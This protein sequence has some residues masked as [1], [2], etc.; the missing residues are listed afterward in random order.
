MYV[1]MSDIKNEQIVSEIDTKDEIIND[2]SNDTIDLG[3]KKVIRKKNKIYAKERKQLLNNVFNIILDDENSCYSH[4]IENNEDIKKQISAFTDDIIKYFNVSRWAVFS[5][6]SNVERK[7][8]STIRS[9]MRD[10]NVEY[11]TVTGKTKV[12]NQY[13]NTTRYKVLNKESYNI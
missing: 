3:K 10:M 13:V 12:N 5:K 9:L 4:I 2:V 8:M 6:E 11:E 7:T 1:I